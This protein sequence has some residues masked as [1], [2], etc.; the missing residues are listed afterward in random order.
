MHGKNHNGTK[1]ACPGSQ[2]LKLKQKKKWRWIGGEAGKVTFQCR[3]IAM[4]NPH[5]HT[6]SLKKPIE[7][8]RETMVWMGKK[9]HSCHG[10]RNLEVR[11]SPLDWAG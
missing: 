11:S 4:Q 8:L 2:M 9:I 1:T 6:Q 5:F 7:A 10:G 3:R